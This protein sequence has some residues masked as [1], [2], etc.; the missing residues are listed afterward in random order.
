MHL[1]L[2]VLLA[3]FSLSSTVVAQEAPEATA[4]PE[5]PE[6]RRDRITELVAGLQDPVDRGFIREFQYS[7]INQAVPSGIYSPVSSPG[8]FS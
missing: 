6:A 1:R 3:A 2:L 4:D 5:A 8:L 7:T